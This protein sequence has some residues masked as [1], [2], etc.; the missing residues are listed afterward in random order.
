M[1]SLIIF[2]AL[3]LAA[4]GNNNN[5]TKNDAGVF[6]DAPAGGPDASCFDLSTI[7]SAAT[8]DQ[9]INACTNAQKIPITANLP[10]L[11]SGGMLPALPD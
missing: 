5:N 9:I 10:L 6:M 7:G 11:G 3:A 1:R 2:T 4:C 8:N